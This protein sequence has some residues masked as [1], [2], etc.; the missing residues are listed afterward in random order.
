M[1]LF[2]QNVQLLSTIF[3]TKINESSIRAFKKRTMKKI[4]TVF[5]FALGMVSAANA[6]KVGYVNTE[7]LL[8]IMPESLKAQKELNDQ[9]EILQRQGLDY[10]KDLQEQDSAFIADSL[11]MTE[12]TKEVMKKSLYELYQKV[13]GWQ[14]YMQNALQESQEQKFGPIRQKAMDAIKAVSKAGNY[15][16]ILDATSVLVGPPG[17]NIIGLLKKHLGIKD[18]AA[19]PASGA[20]KAAPK[21]ATKQ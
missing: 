20:P 6:Q 10:A 8:S 16:Y 4:I 9:Q 13:S 11:K 21:T 1:Q 12:K 17:D 2:C 3:L 5:V 7:E 15:A 14:Q 18:P 19:E